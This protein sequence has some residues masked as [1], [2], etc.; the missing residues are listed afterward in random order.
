VAENG[1]T[2][3]RP[4]ARAIL[5][6]LADELTDEIHYLDRA[7]INRATDTHYVMRA[8]N[9]AEQDYVGVSARFE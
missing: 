4:S 8:Y 9:V 7:T 1:Q 6:A 2:P 3:E 5:L